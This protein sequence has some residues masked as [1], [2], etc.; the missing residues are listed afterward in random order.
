MKNYLSIILRNQFNLFYRFGYT[1]IPKSYLIKYNGKIT[2]SVKENLIKLF[3]ILTP[4]EWE[5]EYLIIHLEKEEL[6]KDKIVKFHIQDLINIYPLSERAKYSLES[7]ID[8]RIRLENPL[9]QDILQKIEQSI[10]NYERET[11]IQIL[12]DICKIEDDLNKFISNIGLEN[13]INGIAKR[14][15][16]TKSSQIQNG[17]YWEYV[18]AYDRY[19]YFPNSILG[20][21]YDAGQIF[22][23]YKGLQS[24]E[25]SGL[26]KFLQ[27]VHNE[28]PDIKF[29][30]IIKLLEKDKNSSKYVTQTT[31]NDQLLYIITPLFLMLKDEI[32]NKEDI[33]N[34]LLFKDLETLKKYG[35]SFKYAIILLGAF[36]GY[37]KFY[38]VYYDHLNLRFYKSFQPLKDK[39]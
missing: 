5:E 11:A 6:I 16:G 30:E 31:L 23:N 33:Q 28:N 9:A 38:D 34:T 4:F 15:R 2:K 10:E 19:D 24:L 17:N 20:Y 1:F 36:F 27:K 22:A 37:K 32:R 14:K 35:N 39:R 18:L 13:L 7:K 25:G 8:Q 21:F 29:Q 3:T 26:Y 12:W